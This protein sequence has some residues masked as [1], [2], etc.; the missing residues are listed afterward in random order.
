MKEN[1]KKQ[2]DIRARRIASFRL[3]VLMIIVFLIM[4]LIV[5]KMIDL[6]SGNYKHYSRMSSKNSFRDIPIPSVRSSIVDRTGEIVALDIPRYRLIR[7]LKNGLWEEELLDFAQASHIAEN[8]ASPGEYV[9]AVPKRSY[10]GGESMAHVTGYVGEVSKEELHR[11]RNKG[12]EPGDRIGKSGLEAWYENYLNGSKGKRKF[13]VDARGNFLGDIDRERPMGGK[14]LRCTIDTRLQKIAYE[15]LRR[16]GRKGAVVFMDSR[17]GELLVLATCPSFEGNLSVEGFSPQAWAGLHDDPENPLLNRAVSV[18]VPVGSVF[19]LV[20]AAAAIQEGIVKPDTMFSCGGRYEL[21]TRVFRCW[22]EAGHGKISFVDAIAESC[23]VVFYQVGRDLG[24]TK[25]KKYA[26]I[27]GFGSKTGVDLPGESIGLLPDPEWKKTFRHSDWYEG[28]TVNLSIGQGF[29][30]ASPIQALVMTNVFATRGMLVTP[31]LNMDSERK[32]E[33]VE[34]SEK[35][36]DIVREGMR[37]AVLSGTAV[38]LR[39][40]PVSSS[41]KTGTAEDKPRPDPHAW[42]VGYAPA[43]RP[44]LTYA[45]FVENGGHGSSDALPI[46]KKV[47]ERAMELGY[48]DKDTETGSML[49]PVEFERGD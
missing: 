23:D 47:L 26:K 3:S 17:S 49:E 40:F 42:Y 41:G 13:F 12:Y 22:K 39:N 9:E 15:E 35:T 24:V 4:L 32:P 31:H 10:P 21:G 30:Q 7:V 27:L 5:G 34:L 8:G 36:I 44:V 48:I 19:K 1:P 6:Q 33:R 25:I 37:R 43:D 46:A 14:P 45:V 11:W 28:D 16:N 18:T 20:V 38:R 29:M 2:I